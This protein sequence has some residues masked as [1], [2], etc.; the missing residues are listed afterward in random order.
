MNERMLLQESFSRI[1]ERVHAVVDGLD[2]NQL[3]W[4][5]APGANPIAWLVWHLTRVQDDHVAEVADTEQAWISAGWHSRFGLDLGPTETGYGHNDADVARVQVKQGSLLLGYYD[6]VH[7]RSLRFLEGLNGDALDR[8]VDTRFHPH[9]T[10][11]V[12]LV[13]VVEDSIEHIG[14]AA[15]LRGLLERQQ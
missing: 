10:L 1:E 11:G 7:A 12:R 9:V 13:S 5:P 14:Q 6:D 4:A 15:Y 3:G 2:S 8:I